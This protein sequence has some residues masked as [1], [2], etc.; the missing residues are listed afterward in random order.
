MDGIQRVVRP[1]CAAAICVWHWRE[2]MEEGGLMADV[3][4]KAAQQLCKDFCK[5]LCNQLIVEESLPPIYPS[6]VRK[7]ATHMVRLGWVKRQQ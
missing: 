3:R 6:W 7:L 2:K 4:L 1:L 5:D